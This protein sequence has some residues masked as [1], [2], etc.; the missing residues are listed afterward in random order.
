MCIYSVLCGYKK[1]AKENILW[2]KQK[3]GNEEMY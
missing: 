2:K 1:A 3:K